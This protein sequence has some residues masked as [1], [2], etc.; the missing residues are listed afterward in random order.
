MPRARSER[1]GG[2][3]GMDTELNYHNQN[4]CMDDGSTMSHKKLLSVHV[5]EATRHATKCQTT[6]AK[7]ITITPRMICPIFSPDIDERKFSSLK[8]T[9]RRMEPECSC[10]EGRGRACLGRRAFS[11]PECRCLRGLFPSSSQGTGSRCVAGLTGSQRD[12][13]VRFLYML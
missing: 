5:C 6:P 2:K 13:G 4:M 3:A 7:H 9:E 10:L 8:M 12:G 1:E 11:T